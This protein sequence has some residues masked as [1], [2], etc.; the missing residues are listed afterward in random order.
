MMVILR[1]CMY[2]CVCVY[3]CVSGGGEGLSIECEL[4]IY[5][6]S[7]QYLLCLTLFVI[8]LYF[9]LL[10]LL[11]SV[12]LPSTYFSSPSP[13][14]F[15]SPPPPPPPPSSSPSSFLP[16]RDTRGCL[17]SCP[18]EAQARLPA[19]RQLHCW[20]QQPGNVMTI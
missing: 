11:L 4:I 14:L 2:V 6:I 20:Q 18:L 12:Y 9:L 5:H 1:V 8:L 15:S 3:V 10:L 13:L 19:R 17:T 7:P 16:S